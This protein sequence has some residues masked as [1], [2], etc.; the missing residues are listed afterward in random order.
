MP[1]E[2]QLQMLAY[3]GGSL[4]GKQMLHF[5]CLEDTFKMK[6]SY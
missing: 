3:T 6:A 2:Y 5:L 4:P 1:A